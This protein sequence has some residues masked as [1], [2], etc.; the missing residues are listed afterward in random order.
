MKSSCELVFNEHLYFWFVIVPISLNL[1][2]EMA[3]AT[4]GLLLGLGAA[5]VNAQSPLYGQ[6][7]LPFKRALRRRVLIDFA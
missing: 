7:K 5:A 6:C 2:A 4:F 3:L 1:S